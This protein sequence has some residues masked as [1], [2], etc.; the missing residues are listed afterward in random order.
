MKSKS[1]QFLNQL[2]P[3]VLLVCFI[4]IHLTFLLPFISKLKGKIGQK[5]VVNDTSRES[6]SFYTRM[7]NT[8]YP[9][10]LT[11]ERIRRNKKFANISDEDAKEIIDGLYKLSI[12][13]YNIFN[14]GTGKL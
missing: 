12:I 14:Y 2:P 10:K 6:A 8:D 1:K 5:I 7:D 4:F 13:S 9:R 3:M 11:I